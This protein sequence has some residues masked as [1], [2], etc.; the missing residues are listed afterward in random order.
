MSKDFIPRKQEAF[1]DLA[2]RVIVVISENLTKFGLDEKTPDGKW[3]R[4]VLMKLYTV[5]ASAFKDWKDLNKRTVVITET[6]KIA[7]KE[8]E[9]LFRQLAGMLKRSPL[10]SDADLVSM[11]LPPRHEGGNKPAP[12]AKDAPWYHAVSTRPRSIEIEYGNQETG[13]H[14]KPPGQHGVECCWLAVDTPRVVHLRELTHSNFDTRTPL[15]LDI[16]DEQR[17]WTVYYAMRWENTR[18]EKGPFGLIESVIVS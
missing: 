12:V 6:L 9:P 14:G 17:G 8:F 7:R 11:G 15:V 16:D 13:K 5:F 18:G 2:E 3:F 1:A 4:E 10:V